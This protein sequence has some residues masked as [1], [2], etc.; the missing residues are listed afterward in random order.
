[1]ISVPTWIR[2]CMMFVFHVVFHLM[3]TCGTAR[4]VTVE[5]K[6]V[7]PFFT[8]ISMMTFITSLV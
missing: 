4:C 2:N 8:G 6:M 1:M 5:K 3:F 7:K